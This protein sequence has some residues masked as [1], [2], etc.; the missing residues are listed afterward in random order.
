[1]GCFEVFFIQ[2]MSIFDRNMPTS[3][4]SSR[5]GGAHFRYGTNDW[6]F[7]QCREHMSTV[8][9]YHRGSYLIIVLFTVSR[10]VEK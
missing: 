5:F 6:T 3:L 1:M 4:C 2:I 10:L 7:M 9:N 8:S